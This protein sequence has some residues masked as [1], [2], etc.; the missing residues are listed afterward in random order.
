VS[1]QSTSSGGAA[2]A[3]GARSRPRGIAGSARNGEGAY[4]C[5][6]G[7]AASGMPAGV[8]REFEPRV[9]SVGHHATGYGVRT[10]RDLDGVFLV[11]WGQLPAYPPAAG[12]QRAVTHRRARPRRRPPAGEPVRGCTW[13]DAGRPAPAGNTGRP[14]SGGW[15]RP[16]HSVAIDRW[17]KPTGC[18]DPRRG[19]SPSSSYAHRPHRLD[20]S[21]RQHP[22]MGHDGGTGDLPDA[23]VE[24][25][26]VGFACLCLAEERRPPC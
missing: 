17:P 16:R 22:W 21:R 6:S 23:R 2:V 13:L 5:A 18:I 25:L 24:H 4:G 9:S 10:G 1:G 3:R 14:L 20:R 11:E 19:C 8:E 12:L 15:V 26:P 7:G